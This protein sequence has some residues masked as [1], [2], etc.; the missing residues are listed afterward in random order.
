MEYA[1]VFNAVIRTKD[2]LCVLFLFFI[3]FLQSIFKTYNHN[4]GLPYN[5]CHLATLVYILL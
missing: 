3:I 1:T 5:S 4:T 2:I